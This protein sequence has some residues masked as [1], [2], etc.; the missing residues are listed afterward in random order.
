MLNHYVHR[1]SVLVY[2][3]LL[4]VSLMNASSQKPMVLYFK[5]MFNDFGSDSNAYLILR[6]EQTLTLSAIRT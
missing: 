3:L 6:R 2:S 4:K 1:S 5:H